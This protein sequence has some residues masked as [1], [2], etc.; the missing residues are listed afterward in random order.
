MLLVSKE[1]GTI[2]RKRKKQ[3]IEYDLLQTEEEKNKNHKG[4]KEYMK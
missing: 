1:Y 3:I 2:K 4:K